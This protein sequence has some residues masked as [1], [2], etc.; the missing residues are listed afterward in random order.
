[1]AEL[2][3]TSKHSCLLAAAVAVSLALAAQPALA[4][5][6]GTVHTG[7][8]TTLRVR[9]G[10][11]SG[12]YGYGSVADGAG[13]DIVCQR[14]GTAV[15]GTQGRSSLWDQMPGAGWV[16]DA[17]VY[18]GSS[19]PVTSPCVYAADPPRANPRAVDDAISWEYSQ[20]GST[21]NEG[22]CLRFQAQAFGWSYGGFY[23]AHTQY[24]WLADRG[25]VSSGVPPR[26]ALA[27]YSTPDGLGH[28]TVSVGAGDIVGTSVNGRVGVAG[29]NYL[30]GYLGWSTPYF[31]NGG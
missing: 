25:L 7:D 21:A 31:A 27:W 1:M 22:W 8:G 28:I 15:S 19:G 20:L 14:T 11:G 12:Y 13:I 5:A 26:G 30:G 4:D 23:S 18:T 3:I 17:Y 6:P 9:A 24:Q 29:Y 16:S 10:P 2:G